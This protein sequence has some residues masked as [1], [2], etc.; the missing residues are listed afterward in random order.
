MISF[1]VTKQEHVLID[2]ISRRAARELDIDPLTTNMDLCACIANG[3]PLRLDE[4]IK[5]DKFDFAHDI[6]GINQHLDHETGEL[7]NFFL[8][9]FYKKSTNVAHT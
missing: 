9:R 2:R 1:E 3:T 6:L 5:A 8:P 7:N 4:L